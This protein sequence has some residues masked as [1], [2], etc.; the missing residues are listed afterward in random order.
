MRIVKVESHIHRTPFTFGASAAGVGGNL[1]LRS[2]DTLL[3]RVETD[4]GLHGWGEGFGFTLVDTTRDALDRLVIPACL[5]EDASDIGG[6]GHRLQRRLHNFGRNGAAS[7]AIAAIDIA[8]WDIA[9]KAAGQP[10]HALLGKAA[11]KRVP[12]YASLLRYGVPEDVARNTRAAVAAGYRRIKLHEVDLA[13]IRAARDAAP[14]D[15]PLMLD[16]N[17][18]WNGV[19]EAHVFCAAVADMNIAWVEEPVWPPEDFAAIA[20][21]RAAAPC[22]IS[23]GE[24]TGSVAELGAMIA[25]GA[26]DVV[27]P[28]VSKLGLSAMLEVG[29]MARRAGIRMVPHSPYFGPGLLAT[30]HLLA[31]LDAEE[32]IEIYAA[33]LARAPYGDALLPRGGF[34]AVPDTPGLGLEPIL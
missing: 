15:I 20:A 6:L 19:E 34:V 9:A 21:V 27:Q 8:L 30:L 18:A 32:P 33:D 13:C 2:M 4:T 22:P 23:A 12:A 25:A 7:F 24:C 26:V 16:I 1:H 31:A 11:R 28:S 10:L 17:C 3:V 14:A 29:A 5:G